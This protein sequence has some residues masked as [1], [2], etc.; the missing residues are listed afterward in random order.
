MTTQ[1][2]FNGQTLVR[3]GAY[4]QIDASQFQ[5]TVL[6]GLGIVGLL[7]EADQGPPR[8]PLSF[9]APVDVKKTYVSGDLVE[10]A[11]MVAD[12]SNDPRIPSGAQQ[13]VCY[14]VN[15]STRSAVT[16]APFVFTSLQWGVAQNVITVAIT[17]SSPGFVVTITN[18][19][20]FGSLI[21]EVSPVIAGTGKF[22]IQY[23]GT[24][25]AAT[26]TTTA[27]T[28]AT[29]VTGAVADNLALNFADYPSLAQLL[30]AIAA[31]GKYAVASLVT[32]SN[33][34]A[35]NQLDLQTAVDV[36]T[37]SVTVFAK[38]A[39]ISGWVNA[40]SQQVSSTFTLAAAAFTG[41]LAATQLTGGTRGT[42]ANTDWVNGFT[43]MSNVRINQTVPL[44]SADAVTAQGT[45]TIA[46]IVAATA[47]YAKLASS[48]AGQNEVQ[49]WVGISQAKTPLIATAN[50]QN[51]EHIVLFGERSQRPASVG[52][53]TYVGGSLLQ[54]TAGQ[55]IFFPEWATA[56]VA[57]GMRAGAPLGEPL[58]WKYGNVSGVSS[59]SSWSEQNNSDVVAME[60][61]GVT[62]INTVRGRGFRF[63]KVITTFTKSNNDAYTEETIV[64]I[65]KLVAFNLRQALQDAFVGRGGSL[66]RVSTVPAVIATVMQPLKDAGAITDSV[67]NGQ[68]LNAWRKVNWSLNGDQLTVS[69]VTTPTPGI[70]YV[71]TTIVLV[72]A[73]ISGAAA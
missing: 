36:K 34:F 55:V 8:V 17:A 47:A 3:P 40:N 1:V 71:L 4:T 7:G 2:L 59:D 69:L 66:Q 42:S 28:L 30:Q 53:Q 62:V 20:A 72:P 27:T 10:A 15:G 24:G 73:Q 39:D 29:T 38:N 50:T 67:V 14:K 43:A 45:F 18:L 56:C 25:S 49:G 19:D 52:G 35:S 46:S 9:L 5:S 61:N 12:P 41:P 6:Q 22:T 13:I 37:A 68:R 21:S 65:W 58:T 60:L 31:T 44:A 57:A 48:T 33:S 32:N 11:A 64:Q 54:Y 16:S 70:N 63:D 26:L 23:T 51:S